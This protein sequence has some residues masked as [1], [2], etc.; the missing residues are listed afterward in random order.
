MKKNI[1]I[2]LGMSLAMQSCQKVIVAKH[3][4]CQEQRPI[5]KNKPIQ[6]T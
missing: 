5:K 4:Y 1:G 6:S 3:E 2:I